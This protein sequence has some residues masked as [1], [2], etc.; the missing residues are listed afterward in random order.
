MS[1]ERLSVHSKIVGKGKKTATYIND[2]LVRKPSKLIK[3]AFRLQK[4]I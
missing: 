2:F 1:Y 4:L 3:K